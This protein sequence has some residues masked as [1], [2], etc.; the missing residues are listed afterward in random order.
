MGVEP[1]TVTLGDKACVPSECVGAWPAVLDMNLHTV[2]H[3]RFFSALDEE[4]ASAVCVIG[5]GIRD[6]LFGAPEEIG[7][8]II[9]IGETILLNGQPFT[10]VGMFTHYMGEQEAKER[11]LAKANP[12]P[13]TSEMAGPKRQKGW[14]KRG[15]W[16]FARKNMT[17]YIPLNTAWVRFLAAGNREGIPDPRLTDIDLK[18]H[19]LSQLETAIQQARNV[20]LMTHNGIEDFNFRTQENQIESINKQI[21]SARLSGGIIAGI[22]LLVGGIGIMNI[23]LASITERIREIGTCKAIGATGTAI[24]IQIIVE[25]VVLSILG[26][27][28]GLLASGLLVRMLSLV[29]PTGNTP[30]VTWEAQALAV[31]FSAGVGIVAGLFPALKAARLSPIQAL[32]YE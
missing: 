14:G 24:F 31:A 22:S 29:S 19:D 3:G 16:A 23:M 21:Q 30:V 10:V 1:M 15:G 18:V 12:K 5:T 25:S 6:A 2:E 9:P 8:E 11:A 26:A 17:M 27:F 7:R 32:R 4:K 20:L 13:A 28:A